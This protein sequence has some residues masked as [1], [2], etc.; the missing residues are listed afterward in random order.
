MATLWIGYGYETNTEKTRN[1]AN[2]NHNGDG[3]LAAARR[4]LPS[5][6][7]QNSSSGQTRYSHLVAKMILGERKK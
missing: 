6:G 7:L 4:I 1:E 3:K 2:S 5:V